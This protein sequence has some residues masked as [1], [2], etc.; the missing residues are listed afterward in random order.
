MLRRSPVDI[1]VEARSTESGYGDSNA[2]EKVE[3][4]ENWIWKWEKEKEKEKEESDCDRELWFLIPF[5]FLFSSI[6]FVVDSV[7]PFISTSL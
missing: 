5:H 4:K 7:T 3:W 6:Y 1:I 2:I